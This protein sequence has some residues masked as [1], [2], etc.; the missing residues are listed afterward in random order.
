MALEAAGGVGYALGHA[1][2]RFVVGLR[3]GTRSSSR[4]RA[5]GRGAR[6]GRGGGALDRR[7]RR[8]EDGADKERHK[9]PNATSESQ[10]LSLFAS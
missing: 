10:H 9:Q 4:R 1:K 5:R 2:E 7:N 6:H 3:G 8:H